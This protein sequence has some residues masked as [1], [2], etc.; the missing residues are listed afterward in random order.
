MEIRQK[1]SDNRRLRMGHIHCGR[2]IESNSTHGGLDLLPRNDIQYPYLVIDK[3]FN[4]DLL[5]AVA[6]HNAPSV[7]IHTGSRGKSRLP[8][9]RRFRRDRNDNAD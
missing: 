7:H 8:E 1:H 5:Q 3:C 9:I 2:N 6:D 4:D